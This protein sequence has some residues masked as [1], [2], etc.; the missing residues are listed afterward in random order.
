LKVVDLKSLWTRAAIKPKSSTASASTPIFQTMES[1]IQSDTPSVQMQAHSDINFE[2]EPEVANTVPPVLGDA[3]A[4]IHEGQH[5]GTDDKDDNDAFYN[6]DWLP[7]DPGERILISDYDFNEQATVRKKYIALGP[8][9]P[10]GHEFP[11]KFIGGNH[12]FVPNW[13][14][15]YDWLEYSVKLDAAFSFV[16]Y[17]LKN[18]NSKG[19]N[20]FVEGGF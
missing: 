15:I 20:S 16:C 1:K 8:C 5:K 14:G 2:V 7:H 4:T 10:R 11:R 13:F 3:A 6:V 9:Q 19:V 12:R 17:L 18:K